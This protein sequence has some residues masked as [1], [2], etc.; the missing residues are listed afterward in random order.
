M[1]SNA[2]VD[3][4]YPK[5]SS[6]GII[7]QN[8]NH[9]VPDSALSRKEKQNDQVFAPT[10]AP[11][12]QRTLLLESEL[13]FAI[14]RDQ[15]E[16]Y[17]QPKID[18]RTNQLVGAEALI[19]WNHPVLG[20]VQPNEFIPLAEI[21]GIINDIGNWVKLTACKQNKA[22]QDANLRAIPISVNLSAT[23][24]LDKDLSAN[25][26]DIL[27]K[28]QIEAKYLEIEI[29]E[30]SLL[31]NESIVFSVLDDLRDLGIKIALDDFGTGY[32]SLSCLNRFKGKIDTLKIDRSFIKELKSSHQED[33]NFIVNMIIQLSKQLKM[34]VI[35]EGVET[36]EQLDVL[37]KYNCNTIQGY[38]Y[39]KPLPACEF[40]QL[41]Q[42]D[43]V[44]PVQ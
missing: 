32:S 25:I 3:H 33:A 23:R 10:L 7:F 34:D 9:L 5:H 26:V 21:S 28:T 24:F 8:N 19:R 29:T 12:I 17:Y 40:A 1:Q 22:W 14:E 31:A 20:V 42:K 16:L 15:L 35:A 36:R 39:S 37:Q 2:S 18:S 4:Y 38:L 41:L 11:Q 30:S 44:E 27:E 43:S 6:N 13:R